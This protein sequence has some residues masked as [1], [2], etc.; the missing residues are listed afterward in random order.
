MAYIRGNTV[1][2]GTLFVEGDIVYN[3]IRPD[4]NGATPAYKKQGQGT[5]TGR[6]LKSA[7]G[8]S[9]GLNDSSI[10]E[11]KPNS[12]DVNFKLTW[13]N[14]NQNPV[15]KITIQNSIKTLFVYENVADDGLSTDLLAKAGNNT[16]SSNDFNTLADTITSWSY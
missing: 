10:I 8:T 4:E 7:D 14:T 13:D 9:G 16:V 12:T 11:T 1:V 5:V 2:D 6:H 3:S 15:E